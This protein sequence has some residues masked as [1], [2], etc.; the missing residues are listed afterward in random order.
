MSMDEADEA[1]WDFGPE[2]ESRAVA[3]AVGRQLKLW[4][5][6]AGMRPAEFGEAMGYGPNLIYKIER[7]ARIPRPEFL[8][9][10]DGILGAG[11]KIAAMKEDVKRARYPKK[12][13]DLTKWEAEAVEVG[14]YGSHNLHGL[15]QT[16][17]YTR[18]LF[19]MRRP[20]YSQDHIERLTEARLA[21]R[22]IFDRSPAPA[23]TFVQEEVTLRRPIGGTMV[24]RR[25]LERLLQVG[26][27]RTVE[28]Q[29]MPTER[30]DHAG[31]HGEI[32]VLKFRD[33]SAVGRSEGQF[34]SRVIS[35][36]QQL[37]ILELRYGIVRAQAL[38]PRESLAFIE[39]VLGET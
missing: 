34:T 11:G 35:N 21:R 33:G 13:R 7:G 3:Q 1:S 6:E 24:L 36:P 16:E 12:V 25:Q 27:L 29:V 5:E 39:K 9:K 22:S 31:M 8:D 4:R 38:T 18:A 19:E 2:D 37:R 10:A 15:L 26:Q 23:L 20:A 32:E 17:E 30:E 28:I 14:W